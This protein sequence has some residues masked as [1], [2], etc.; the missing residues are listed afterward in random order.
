[1]IIGTR[2]TKL[3][4]KRVPPQRLYWSERNRRH[5]HRLLKIGT[6]E[7]WFARVS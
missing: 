1:M 7:L 6:W 5:R 2:H 3:Y 4:T